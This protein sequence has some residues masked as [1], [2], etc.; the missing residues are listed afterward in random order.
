MAIAWDIFFIVVGSSLLHA[1][2]NF[3]AR[4]TKGNLAVYWL[5]SWVS[6]AI[7]LPFVIYIMVEVDKAFLN[8]IQFTFVL[9]TGERI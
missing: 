6:M 7:S 4:R 5:G 2:W 9:S 8:W 1:T 3:F